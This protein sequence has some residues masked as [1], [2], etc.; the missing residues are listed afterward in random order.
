MLTPRGGGIGLCN[1][2]R[3]CS[4]KLVQSS[5]GISSLTNDVALTFPFSLE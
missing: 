4:I 5:L 3:F 2:S 1:A